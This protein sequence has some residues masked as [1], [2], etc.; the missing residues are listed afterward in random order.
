M[1]SNSV[2][3]LVASVGC[4]AM[5]G[6]Y[7]LSTPVVRQP[8]GRIYSPPWF[9]RSPPTPASHFR[10]LYHHA[11]D[12]PP[13]DHDREGGCPLCAMSERSGRVGA[14]PL[15]LSR[16]SMN[17]PRRCRCG[18]QQVFGLMEIPW[19]TLP[20]VFPPAA[21]PMR[22]R[23]VR[24]PWPEGC[25]VFVAISICMNSITGFRVLCTLSP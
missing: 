12:D 22:G 23:V 14:L 20:R 7:R 15:H 13:N 1:I 6:P 2:S 8:N 24:F 5:Q 19:R 9:A 4:T 17:S 25:K 16:F 21:Q 18:D 11:C 10:R 3:M